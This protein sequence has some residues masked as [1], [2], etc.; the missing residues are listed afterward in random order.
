MFRCS[1]IHLLAST[2]I[3]YPTASTDHCLNKD[4]NLKGFPSDWPAT[5]EADSVKSQLREAIE[6]AEHA[7]ANLQA[8]IERAKERTDYNSAPTSLT[9]NAAPS[10]SS[11][12]LAHR[13]DP[14][15]NGT[16][17]TDP[18]SQELRSKGLSKTSCY[19]QILRACSP[20][21]QL[22]GQCPEEYHNGRTTSGLKLL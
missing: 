9:D 19:L 12:Q 14:A 3:L 7:K 15:F 1:L 4:Q 16:T 10:T 2:L 6:A 8:A 18:K 21:M 11:L 20:F 17:L 5:E 22:D 13:S